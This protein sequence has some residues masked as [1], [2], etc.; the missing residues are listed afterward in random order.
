VAR[1]I[2]QD[3][4]EIGGPALHTENS[5][6]FA[7]LMLSW[8]IRAFRN[9]STVSGPVFFDR[10]VTELV[11]YLQLIGLPVPEH[12]LRAAAKF[13]Y[14]RRVFLAPH[15]PAIY[16]NDAER[17]QSLEE[18]AETSER[19]AAAYVGAG[20]ELITLPLVS[21]AERVA[22]VLDVCGLI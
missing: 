11:G 18:A 10:G 13:R 15:W 19:V 6:L 14:D 2:I 22:F 3:Q 4:L 21:I 8:E 7:E 9:A 17:R 12:F 16:V 20:Y 1:E 5:A